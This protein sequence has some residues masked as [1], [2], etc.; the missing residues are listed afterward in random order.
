[1]HILLNIFFSACNKKKLYSFMLYLDVFETKD[2]S[3]TPVLISINNTDP[4][5]E[6]YTTIGLFPF[7]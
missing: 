4:K 1:M 5:V 3:F 6:Q 7:E 2:W